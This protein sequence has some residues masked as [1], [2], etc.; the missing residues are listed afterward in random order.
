[1]IT[2]VHSGRRPGRLLDKP[3]DADASTQGRGNTE[4]PATSAAG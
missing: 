2:E 3:A 1:M 4:G